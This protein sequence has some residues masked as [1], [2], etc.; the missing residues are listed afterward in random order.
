MYWI[1]LIPLNNNWTGIA[2]P[3]PLQR[4]WLN[5]FYNNNYC[6]IKNT[7]Y[8]LDTQKIFSTP[9]TE[10]LTNTNNFEEPFANN[11]PVTGNGLRI[12][13]SGRLKGISKAKKL[14]ITHGV[15]RSQSINHKLDYYSRPIYTKWGT[16]GLK[17]IC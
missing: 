15:I 8:S 16:I 3:L 14:V 9:S 6:K 4:D 11:F 2:L 12:T 1:P 17:V 5:L 13:V 10:C 7:T